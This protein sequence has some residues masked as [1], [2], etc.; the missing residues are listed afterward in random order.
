[1]ATSSD[2]SN[3]PIALYEAAEE[4][5][6]A[7]FGLLGPLKRS[8]EYGSIRASVAD[9]KPLDA[10]QQDMYHY[11]VFQLRTVEVAQA[12]A[13]PPYALFTM[14]WENDGPVSALVIA[15]DVSQKQAKVVNLSMP[16]SV[17]TVSLSKPETPDGDATGQ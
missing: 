9:P 11:F 13:G 5:P 4:L 2:A 1:M 6:C 3:G 12:D 17:Q 16:E 8:A 14:S 10:W 7:D 15:P